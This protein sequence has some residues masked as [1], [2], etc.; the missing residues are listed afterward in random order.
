[1]TSEIARATHQSLAT[2]LV[3]RFGGLQATSPSGGNGFGQHLAVLDS[4]EPKF[5]LHRAPMAASHQVT[6][7]ALV[8][9]PARRDRARSRCARSAPMLD[10]NRQSKR[11]GLF[12]DLPA[13]GCRRGRFGIVNRVRNKLIQ[14]QERPA[15]LEPELLDTECI[16]EGSVSR[17]RIQTVATGQAVEAMAGQV[18]TTPA[19][20]GER[21]KD[22][23]EPAGSAPRR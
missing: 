23:G 19:R 9:E 13:V 21:V 5:L 20:Q 15:Q 1:M 4:I 16:H 12:K 17:A 11:H 14:S 7:S 3:Y 2:P 6:R 22:H 10:A 8:N 18:G